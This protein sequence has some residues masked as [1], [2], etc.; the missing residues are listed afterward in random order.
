MSLIGWAVLKVT[1]MPTTHL[2]VSIQ[3]RLSEGVLCSADATI[4]NA[5]LHQR[6]LRISKSIGFTP[7]S[8]R[9][10]PNSY[11]FYRKWKIMA[12]DDVVGEEN[13]KKTVSVE[14][15]TQKKSMSKGGKGFGSPKSEPSASVRKKGSNGGKETKERTSSSPVIRRTPLEKP[16]TVP[17][18][19][20]KIEENEGAFLITWAALGILILVEGV[21]LAASG[22]LP[23]EWDYFLVKY[24]YPSFTPTV[25]VFFAG[26]AAYGLYKYLGG[27]S[28]KS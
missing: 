20:P 21:V 11:G 5:R 19:D 22:F 9:V 7:C 12:S 3:P 6:F 26:T 15:K 18:G 24:L 27:G 4:S 8:T 13:K 2:S 16:F 25:A 10:I 1:A 28:Q 14:E 17:Q 23:E